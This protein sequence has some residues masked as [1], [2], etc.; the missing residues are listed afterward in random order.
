MRRA[1]LLLVLLVGLGAAPAPAATFNVTDN[2]DGADDTPGDGNC[3]TA[4]AVCTLRAC[5]QEANDGA[6]A[7]TCNVAALNITPAT[8]LAGISA[9]LTIDGC[10]AAGTTLGNILGGTDHVLTADILGG[11]GLSYGLR[12]DSGVVTIRCLEISGFDDVPG[13]GAAGIKIFGGVVNVES[14]IL[15][16]NGHGVD[17]RGGFVTIGGLTSTTGNIIRDNIVDGVFCSGTPSPVTG[18]AVVGNVITGNEDG[19]YFGACDDGTIGGGSAA[20]RNVISDNTHHG[21]DLVDSDRTA[22]G[23]NRIGTNRA[24]T[25]ADPNQSNGIWVTG[26]STHTLIS[27]SNLISGNDDWGIENESTTG[28]TTASG[29]QIGLNASGTPSLCN[30][31]GNYLDE[32]AGTFADNTVCPATPTPTPTAQGCCNY[33]NVVVDGGGGTPAVL[34]C[35]DDTFMGSLDGPAA[36]YTAAAAVPPFTPGPGTPGPTVALYVAGVSCDGGGPFGGACNV[37]ATPSITPTP[38]VT[39][40]PTITPTSVSSPTPTEGCPAVVPGTTTRLSST[41][42]MEPAALQALP[43]LTNTL[44]CESEDEAF[45]LLLTAYVQTGQEEDAPKVR[46]RMTDTGNL[47]AP[48]ELSPVLPSGALT[49]VTLS[50]TVY[51]GSLGLGTHTFEIAAQKAGGRGLMNLNTRTNFAITNFL[52]TCVGGGGAGAGFS[53]CLDEV[54]TFTAAATKTTT[55]TLAARAQVA[56]CYAQNVTAVTGGYSVGLAGAPTGWGAVAATLGANNE[57]DVSFSRIVSMVA[58]QGVVL[59]SPGTFTA[60]QQARVTCYCATNEG[61]P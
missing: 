45:F 15:A 34:T 39:Q 28:W 30:G 51:C 44:L 8:A 56:G 42:T 11:T 16:E 20:H 10:G 41:T 33:Q 12:V 31:A 2:G 37:T 53:Q 60:G 5:I 46:L 58:T 22:I 43:S 29:N 13:F 18:P 3:A 52:T 59:T 54:V 25:A 55:A 23:F 47:T 61:A 36:C 49:A 9:S 17:T 48:L 32:D 6:G 4:G 27:P 14:S 1:L 40:T 19:V 7:D 24:G 57:A 35:G 50:Q 38:S 26:T 21:I